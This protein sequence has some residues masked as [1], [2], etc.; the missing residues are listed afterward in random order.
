MHGALHVPEI[1]YAICAEMDSRGGLSKLSRV[2][3]DWYDAA[4]IR[5]W[6]HLDSLLPLLCLLPADSWEMAASEASSPRRVFTLTRPLTPLDWAPVL[7]RS[8]LVKALRERIDGTPPGIGVEALETM[9][10]S[11]PPFTL[12][13]HLQDLSFPTKGYGT[14]SAF[15]FQLISP[16]LRVLQVHGSWPD[17]ISVMRVAD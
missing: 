6:E 16:S 14:H 8:I 5:L 11:P 12:L 15:Y 3:R 1:R 2:S 13:P 17:G 10:R 9:C 4:N 7:K